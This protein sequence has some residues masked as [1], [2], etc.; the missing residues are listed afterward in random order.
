MAR[1]THL[2]DVDVSP[3]NFSGS[4]AFRDQPLLT[5]STLIVRKTQM[6]T[7]SGSITLLSAAAA[8]LLTLTAAASAQGVARGA[9]DGFHHGNR[10]AGPVGAVVGGAVGGVVGGVAGGVKG[11]LGVPQDTRTYN[12]RAHDNRNVRVRRAQPS[13]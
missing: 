10:A 11:V 6:T 8:A 7:A 4:A 9:E 1:A 12:Q 2:A 3:M 5:G 13:Y